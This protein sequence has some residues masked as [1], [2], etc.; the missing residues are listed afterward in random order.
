MD[1]DIT[2][3]G[4][5]PVG[6][7]AA[8]NANSK[9]HKVVILEQ[10][11]KIGYPDH[12]AGLISK[13]GLELIGIDSL[14][15]EI[16]QNKNIKGA[17]FYSP[18]GLNFTVERK[19]SQAV[20]LD[21][22]LF[23]NFLADKARKEGAQILL[24]KKVLSSKI[25]DG[26]VLFQYKDK[27]N[28]NISSIN[29]FVGIIAEGSRG[30]VAKQAG[31][32][33]IPEKSLL[34]AYQVL[35]EN[36]VDLDPEY[37]ELYANNHFAPGFFA[38]IIPINDNSAKVG[39]ASNKKMSVLRLNDFMNK[40]TPNIERFSK[41]NIIKKYGGEVIVRGLARKTSSFGL[42][43]A[44]DV[45][46]QT[47]STTGGGVIT[48]GLAGMIAGKIVAKAVEEN[49]NSSLFLKKY[50]KQWKKQLKSQF[51]TMALFRWCVNRLSDKA[52]DQAFATVVEN[53]LVSLIEEKADIDSQAEILI[54]LLKHPAVLKLAFK[55][56]PYLQI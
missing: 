35:V 51:R 10:R 32:R 8:I 52:L 50:D 40:Y 44:G 30:F 41:S 11:K 33:Q 55:I 1:S 45:A 19:K 27:S 47:K 9:K 46:G 17:K 26:E 28:G 16:I 36:V 5:G 4:A 2:I 22:E 24:E 34:S 54:S 53:D 48:G 37:V 7:L 21:R 39:L 14:P 6:S 3:V 42:L 56:L 43:L 15:S 25:K 49:N 29:S 38:W 20:V 31:F 23:D 13:N 18:S 12:C